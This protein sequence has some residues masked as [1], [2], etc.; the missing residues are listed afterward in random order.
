MV[1]P[2][3]YDRVTV[4]ADIFN[5]QQIQVNKRTVQIQVLRQGGMDVWL[6]ASGWT[7]AQ[8]PAPWLS[9]S[10]FTV[11]YANTLGIRLQTIPATLVITPLLWCLYTDPAAALQTVLD[12]QT[13]QP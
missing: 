5:L 12:W 3:V 4:K 10:P 2:R 7:S 1:V 6:G 11:E 13:F 9:E 8:H